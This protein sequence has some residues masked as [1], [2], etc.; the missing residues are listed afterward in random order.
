MEQNTG[1]QLRTARVL[2]GALIFSGTLFL[3]LAALISYEQGQREIRLLPLAYIA[4]TLAVLSPGMAFAAR[5]VLGGSAGHAT[6]GLPQ[7]PAQAQ[8]QLTA[9][10]V[11]FALLESVVLL[12]AVAL[13]ATDVLWLLVAGAVP[14]GA[15]LASFPR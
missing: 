4:A 7:D 15:M 13:F 12:C 8:R 11:S 2:A 10:I 9:T 1:H 5:A 3:A 6:R 14:L